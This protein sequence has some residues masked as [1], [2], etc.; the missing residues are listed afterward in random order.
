M[1]AMCFSVHL[2][3]LIGR[4]VNDILVLHFSKMTGVGCI[5][6]EN[7]SK[8]SYQAYLSFLILIRNHSCFI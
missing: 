8:V 3:A 7:L 4:V 5:L 6:S 2:T 1:F